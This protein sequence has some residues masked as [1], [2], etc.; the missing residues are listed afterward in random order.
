MTPLLEWVVA[1]GVEY[2]EEGV[3]DG[4][5]KEEEAQEDE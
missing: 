2:I 5:Q 1:E 4:L 3:G